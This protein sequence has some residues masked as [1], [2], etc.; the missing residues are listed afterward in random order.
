MNS[1]ATKK[2]RQRKK[3]GEADWCLSPPE[4]LVR[5][6]KKVFDKTERGKGLSQR[7]ISDKA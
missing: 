6:K 5:E 4:E 7:A 2:A 1:Y 3:S